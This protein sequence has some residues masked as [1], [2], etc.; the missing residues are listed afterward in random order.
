[1]ALFEQ[2]RYAR[3]EKQIAFS[4]VLKTDAV[5]Q[6]KI[7]KKCPL[8]DFLAPILSFHF[9]HSFWLA[10]KGKKKLA[11]ELWSTSVPSLKPQ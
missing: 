3:S 4:E 10:Y 2:T 7:S 5:I 11:S 9:F 1:M 6:K 8:W